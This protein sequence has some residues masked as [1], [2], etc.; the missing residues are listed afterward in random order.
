MIEADGRL[1]VLEVTKYGNFLVFDRGNLDKQTWADNT[2]TTKSGKTG[3][4]HIRQDKSWKKYWPVLR[5]HG[6]DV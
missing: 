5:K 4:D 6:I 1:I 2:K 3:L